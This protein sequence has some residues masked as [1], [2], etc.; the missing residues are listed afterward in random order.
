MKHFMPF[1]CT[2]NSYGNIDYG[3]PIVANKWTDYRTSTGSYH[4]FIPNIAQEFDC[5][6]KARLKSELHNIPLEIRDETY[7]TMY[8]DKFGLKFL[9]GDASVYYPCT[10]ARHFEHLR[11]F[12][13][14]IFRTP[15]PLKGTKLSASKE[16]Y[17]EFAN[18]GS[19][20]V[21]LSEPY[22]ECE[23]KALGRDEQLPRPLEEKGYWKL[24]DPYLSTS[25]ATYI[26]F[27]VNRQNGVKKDIFTL[28]NGAKATGFEVSS[29]ETLVSKSMAMHDKLP[30]KVHPSSGKIR[31]MKKA[32]PNFGKKSEMKASYVNQSFSNMFAYL[33]QNEIIY[34]DSLPKAT[35]VQNSSSSGMYCTESCH[36]GT[37]RAVNTVI[38]YGL[39]HKKVIYYQDN[40]T[41]AHKSV[42]AVRNSL[43]F[44]YGVLEYPLQAKSV[45]GRRRLSK[46]FNEDEAFIN[47]KLPKELILRIFSYLDVVSLCRCAQVSKLWNVLAL[48]GSNWQRID[49]FD[50]QKDVEGPI[51]ENISRRC[52]GFLRQLSLRGCQ[53]IADGSM[54]TLAQLCPNVED[55]NLNGCKKIT[56]TTCQSLSK[57]CSKLQKL[58]LDSCSAITDLSLKALSDG[59]SL[60]SQIN[61]SWCSNITESG[62]EALARGCPKLKSFVSKGCRQ[63]TSRAVICLARFC[64]NLEIVNLLGCSNIRD[65]AVQALAEKCNKLHYLCLSGCSQLTDASLI[66]LAQQCPFLSTLE[67][68]GCS[69]FTDAAFQALARSC[70]YLEK[71]DLDECILITDATLIHLSMGCPRIEYLTLSHCELITDEGIRHLSMSPCAAENLTVLE[72]DNCPLVTDASL[73]HLTSCHNLQR[74]ELYDCQLITRVGI[75]RLRLIVMNSE[76]IKVRDGVKTFLDKAKSRSV[77]LHLGAI[78]TFDIDSCE[79]N[80]GEAGQ[81]EQSTDLPWL[82]PEDYDANNE[83]RLLR[84]GNAAEETLIN[85]T[86]YDLDNEGKYIEIGYSTHLNLQP[87]I[88]IW[89]GATGCANSRCNARFS[90]NNVLLDT[91]E[92]EKFTELEPHMMNQFF[93]D[94]LKSSAFSINP[95]RMSYPYEICVKPMT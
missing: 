39:P 85:S 64:E 6:V 87:V 34:P 11:G 19:A 82:I 90:K 24:L 48:D 33:Y 80:T 40:T 15:P 60:L 46:V 92:W 59:C 30:F 36:L 29:M 44:H 26:P 20:K 78:L 50:F 58:N 77:P 68:A 94:S 62:V 70:R 7:L 81:V 2:N 41:S 52:G 84:Y 42:L 73:E 18:I 63:I 83:A 55:L 61:I 66:S 57:H 16:S 65:E 53:S 28:H 76:F 56:D 67:V 37:G 4:K 1:V 74:I 25:R 22:V 31:E 13:E 23:I 14:K 51:I 32:I 9:Q 69:Q 12:Q 88:R 91:Y 45:C 71:M 3:V 89:D 27:N 47:K 49:L 72:L 21:F 93:Y 95:P 54:K 86:R 8:N 43:N 5:R 10:K 35:A 75:R 17:Q 38:D 79:N